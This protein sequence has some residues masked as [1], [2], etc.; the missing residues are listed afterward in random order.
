MSL[1][2]QVGSTGVTKRGLLSSEARSK[3]PSIAPKDSLPVSATRYKKA[4]KSHSLAESQA[5]HLSFAANPSEHHPLQGAQLN[6]VFNNLSMKPNVHSLSLEGNLLTPSAILALCNNI[7]MST[8]R[9]TS[10]NLSMCGLG[11]VPAMKIIRAVT[12]QNSGDGFGVL[13]FLDMSCNHISEKG[14]IM[15]AKAFHKRQMGNLG[16]NKTCDGLSGSCASLKSR[17]ISNQT[18]QNQGDTTVNIRHALFKRVFSDCMMSTVGSAIDSGEIHKDELRELIPTSLHTLVLRFNPIGCRGLMELLQSECVLELDV[19]YCNLMHEVENEEKTMSDEVGSA[20]K[21][22]DDANNSHSRSTADKEDDTKGPISDNRYSL[23]SKRSTYNMK[24]EQRCP[25]A[26]QRSLGPI[27]FDNLQSL[28]HG[29]AVSKTVIR[30][31]IDGN[32]L[33]SRDEWITEMEDTLI[34]HRNS[35]LTIESI[36]YGAFIGPLDAVSTYINKFAGM[37]YCSRSKT[38]PPSKGV[39]EWVNYFYPANIVKEVLL[40]AGHSLVVRGYIR[41]VSI[42]DKATCK[43]DRCRSIDPSCIDEKHEETCT[44]PNITSPRRELRGK[45]GSRTRSISNR[46]EGV[47]VNTSPAQRDVLSVIHSNK[48]QKTTIGVMM[49]TPRPCLQSKRIIVEC[50]AWNTNSSVNPPV[51]NRIKKMRKAEAALRDVRRAE[52]WKENLQSGLISR[53]ISSTS[54]AVSSKNQHINPTVKTMKWIDEVDDITSNNTK[55]ESYMV[56]ES[57]AISENNSFCSEKVEVPKLSYKSFKEQFGSGIFRRTSF[58]SDSSSIIKGEWTQ[59]RVADVTFVPPPSQYEV[60]HVYDKQG[61][62]LLGGDDIYMGSVISPR[63]SQTNDVNVNGLIEHVPSKKQLANAIRLLDFAAADDDQC[64]MILN[65]R[66]FSTMNHPPS[67]SGISN[68]PRRLGFVTSTSKRMLTPTRSSASP[69]RRNDWSD[70]ANTVVYK[71]QLRSPDGGLHEMPKQFL[72]YTALPS[73]LGDGDTRINGLAKLLWLILYL[74]GDRL[75]HSATLVLSDVPF[76][77][78]SA[79]IEVV[80]RYRAMRARENRELIKIHSSIFD[81]RRKCIALL[82]KSNG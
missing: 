57:S 82:K 77:I 12:R 62:C 41:D 32:G 55:G 37:S 69:N 31:R 9:L 10:I 20:N 63:G 19:R 21:V 47:E 17:S 46:V 26:F 73:E 64:F 81:E 56:G 74:P 35:S 52:Q 18:T 79:P 61:R 14:A 44:Y 65:M 22:V 25:T 60:C 53:Q 3:S 29:V 72:K 50:A 6:S 16:G 59:P 68:P 11:D 34:V 43:V 27:A 40:L 15:I 8:S 78:K 58:D 4:L 45:S 76:S 7:E 80:G 23:F 51:L 38:K 28:L 67:L 49:D 48:L 75:D 54:K 24:S 33:E 30:L 1:S 39:S 5:V 70:P 36:S 13:G 2:S 71:Q 66:P 42:T